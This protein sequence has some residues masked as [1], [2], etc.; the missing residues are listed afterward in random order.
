MLVK[1]YTNN[2]EQNPIGDW[3]KD[4]VLK[5]IGKYT[6]AALTMDIEGYVLFMA[7]ALG[8]GRE[9]IQIYIAHVRKELAGKYRPWYM[10]QVVWAR[11]PE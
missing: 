2:F 7:N 11:K 5:D 10:H 9:E 1:S 8:W 6:H 4:P 3:P